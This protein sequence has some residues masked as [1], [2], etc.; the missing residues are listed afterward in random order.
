MNTPSEY[1]IDDVI[2]EHICD[3]GNLDL[4]SP[5]MVVTEDGDVHVGDD[6][7]DIRQTVL[8][9]AAT[10]KL[11]EEIAYIFCDGQLMDADITIHL[12]QVPVKERSICPSSM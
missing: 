1:G 12:K 6:E 9:L 5:F 4:L 3:S 11:G 8:S 2:A 10:A 7:E